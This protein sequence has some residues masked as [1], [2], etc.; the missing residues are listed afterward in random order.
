[1][2][3]L[4]EQY[5]ENLAMDSNGDIRVPDDFIDGEAPEAHVLPPR[6]PETEAS[7]EVQN[8]RAFLDAEIEVSK[9][10]KNDHLAVEVDGKKILLAEW[11]A[12]DLY[13]L[14][15]TDPERERIRADYQAVI[16]TYNAARAPHLIEHEDETPA[17][18]QWSKDYDYYFNRGDSDFD[19]RQKIGDYPE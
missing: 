16:D 19:I 4:A 9:A 5:S 3:R 14:P 8:V 13:K 17:Q 1:M 18:I 11:L 12:D 10:N 6:S 7:K 2:T 15:L